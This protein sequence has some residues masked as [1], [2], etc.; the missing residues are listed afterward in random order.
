[1]LDAV[2][3]IVMTHAQGEDVHSLAVSAPEPL[4]S[5][6]QVV[7]LTIETGG[8]VARGPGSVASHPA[9]A[10]AA[11]RDRTEAIRESPIVSRPSPV[12]KMLAGSRAR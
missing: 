10:W 12:R 5:K 3:S 2:S 7:T 4:R 9:G 8:F 11:G 1:M 6:V